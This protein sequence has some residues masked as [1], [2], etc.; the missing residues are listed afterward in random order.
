MIELKLILLGI[1]LYM[2]YRGK[3]VIEEGF[4]LYED[5]ERE[6]VSILMF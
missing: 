1:I 4:R 6:Q 2:L 5:S 3:S